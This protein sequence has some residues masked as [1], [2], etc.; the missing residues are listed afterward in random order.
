MPTSSAKAKLV[1]T[2]TIW[3][4]IG[5]ADLVGL[6]R[7]RGLVRSGDARVIRLARGL[8]MGEVA[9]SVGVT[10]ATVSRW[11]SGERV[12]RGAPALRYGELLDS[13]TPV[14]RR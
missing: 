4:V 3:L 13:L 1:L 6:A 12:P 10:V 7:V 9:R 11:E 14:S 8:T 2:Y 5:N